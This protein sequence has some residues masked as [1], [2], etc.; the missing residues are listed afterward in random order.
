MSRAAKAILSVAVLGAVAVG[1]FFVFEYFDHHEKVKDA[2]RDCTSEL[3]TPQAGVALP[4]SLKGFSLPSDQTLLE[5]D[6]QG[7]TIV[8]YTIV[9][10]SRADLV[11]LRD[12]VV[13][14]MNGLGFKASATDQ[15]PTYEA[16]GQ[17]TGTLAGTIQVQPQCEGYDR[18]RYKFN[19]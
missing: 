3:T 4:S 18:I 14:Q 11:S 10:G 16:E 17:F 8:V 19:L 5:V 2:T 9:K 6:S 1:G 7:K 12:K 15:E 13:T